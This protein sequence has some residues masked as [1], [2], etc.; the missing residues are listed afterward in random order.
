M[1]EISL[2]RVDN[3]IV[4]RMSQYN[5]HYPIRGVYLDV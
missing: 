3:I 5:P 4:V 1:V 2:L